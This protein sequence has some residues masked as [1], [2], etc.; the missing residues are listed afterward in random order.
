MRFFGKR[1]FFILL[2]FLIVLFFSIF[3]F[4]DLKKN[5]EEERENSIFLQFLS[6]FWE[7]RKEKF[8]QEM[9]KEIEEM[10]GDLLRINKN[11]WQKIWKKIENILKNI[12]Q[13]L[14]N[15]FQNFR[16]MIFPKMRELFP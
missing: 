7:K 16:K 9:E 8:F 6:H 11:F 12:W 2:A 3:F 15:F 10:K 1:N 5:F 13:G 14:N 4:F